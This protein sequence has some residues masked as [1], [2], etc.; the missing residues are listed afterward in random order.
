VKIDGNK[1]T[2]TM[3]IPQKDLGAVIKKIADSSEEDLEKIK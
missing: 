1:I 2:A 3:K